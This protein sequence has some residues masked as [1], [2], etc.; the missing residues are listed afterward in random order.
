MELFEFLII[1]LSMIVG[2][3]LIRQFKRQIKK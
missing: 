3:G 1:L 2:L